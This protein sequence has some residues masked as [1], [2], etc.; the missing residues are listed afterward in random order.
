M[1]VSARKGMDAGRGFPSDHQGVGGE[2][3]EEDH[4]AQCV[5][6]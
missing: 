5:K 6:W 1:K 3:G 2:R 4:E